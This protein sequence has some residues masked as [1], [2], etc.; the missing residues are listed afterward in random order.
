MESSTLHEAL[1]CP[2]CQSALSG[3]APLHCSSCT[4]VYPTLG[5]VRCLVPDPKYWCSI[6]LG[7]VTSYGELVRQRIAELDARLTSNALSQRT[8][9]RI[10]RM[11][12]GL[13]SQVTQI[14]AHFEAL[15]VN[16]PSR[17]SSTLA[18]ADPSSSVPVLKC[19][20][21]L[22]RDW[23]W[24]NAESSQSF[25]LVKKIAPSTLGRLAVYGAGA[26]RLAVDVH[27]ALKPECTIALDINPFP[28]LV[29]ARLAQG[30]R[31]S[32]PEFPVGPHSE[33]DTVV[34]Q[35]L[36]CTSELGNDFSFA[37]G[38]ALRPP[39]APGSLDTILSSWV[40]DALDADFRDTATAVNRVLRPGGTWLNIGPLRFDGD[41]AE[42]YSIEEVREIVE[43]CGFAGADASR[44]TIDYFRSPHSGSH[45]LETVFCFAA[46]KVAEAPFRVVEGAYTPW[47][48]ETDQPIPVTQS[49]AAMRRN[50]VITIGILSLVDGKRSLDDIAR[51]LAAQWKVAP[52][53]L[54]EPLRDFFVRLP[55]R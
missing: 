8:A 11:K 43:A 45:R 14:S 22:F 31:V 20:E 41:V 29:A 33:A 16:T 18:G 30:E 48:V 50:S 3:S 19:Y 47:L 13:E 52:E 42:A 26:G 39:F 44:E 7:R 23:A 24:G 5:G 4:R 49:S 9:R 6:W 27:V 38:D 1:S 37:F 28:L 12:T 2:N 40:I 25:E 36:A 32:L 21:N 51:A 46:R 54:V 34:F 15:R 17:P 55:S 35:T 53:T 10:Q